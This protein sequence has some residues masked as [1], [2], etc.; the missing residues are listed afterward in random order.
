M[1]VFLEWIIHR[2]TV[3]LRDPRGVVNSRIQLPVFAPSADFPQSEYQ[4]S[5]G[6]S[7]SK[8]NGVDHPDL[9]ISNDPCAREYG[10]ARQRRNAGESKPDRSYHPS[11]HSLSIVDS[12]NVAES[13]QEQSKTQG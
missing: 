11:L 4:A 13:V 8:N 3:G 10:R 6:Y 1:P 9:T 7:N 12:T 5:L 2:S